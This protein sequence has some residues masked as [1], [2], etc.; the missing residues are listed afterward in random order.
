MSGAVISHLTILG[1]EHNGD[2][3][4]LFI[5]AILTLAASETL[6]IINR[7]DIPIIGNKFS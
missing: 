2:G 7:K 5:G 3:G 1:I 4:L 6:L